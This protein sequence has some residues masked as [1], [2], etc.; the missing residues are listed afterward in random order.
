MYQ[1]GNFIKGLFNETDIDKVHFY[2][3]IYNFKNVK[4]WSNS[5]KV[6]RS[7]NNKA[8]IT[9]DGEQLKGTQA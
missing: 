6:L 1:S 4:F 5:G 9:S 8:A 2:T 7:I 3:W